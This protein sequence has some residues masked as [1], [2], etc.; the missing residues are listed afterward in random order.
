MPKLS[1][2]KLIHTQQPL[3]TLL[4]RSMDSL[5]IAFA[6]VICAWLLGSGWS[7][8]HTIYALVGV[9]AMQTVG[10]FLAIY[11]NWSLDN[12]LIQ[13]GMVAV[14]W[15]V[16]C[17]LLIVLAVLFERPFYDL[18]FKV[19]IY[20]VGLTTALLGFS[21]VVVKTGIIWL[22][23]HDRNT[24]RVAIAGAGPLAG[25]VI[26]KLKGNAW[27]D[28]R[29]T[30]IYDDR[31]PN[32]K[33]AANSQRKHDLIEGIQEVSGIDGNFDDLYRAAMNNDIDVVFVALPMRAENKIQ[34]ITRE[35]SATTVATYIV[36]DFYSIETHYT[37]LVDINGMPAVSIYENPTRGLRGIVKRLEDFILTC[38][39]LLI[40]GLPMVLIALGVKL[41]SKGPVFFMQRRY[42]LDGKPIKV[43]KFRSMRVM[44]NGEKVT[45]ATK[46][47]PRVTAFGGFLRKT[48]LDE[49][50]Q[51]FNVLFGTMSLVGPRPHAVSHNEEYRQVIGGYMLRHK[52]KPGITGWAQINGFR[53]ETDTLDKMEGRVLYDIDYIRHWSVFLD[54]KILFLTI[55]KGFV[56]K[57]AY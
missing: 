42:G 36:P 48:S 11:R 26:K 16:A 18:N 2:T 44:E 24:R 13:S 35:L 28:Y 21:R 41:S 29:M 50:P 54:L 5:V 15:L 3:V 34:T 20:W 38:G 49:L 7:R 37:H 23:K 30:G 17:A 53:G 55:F 51:L 40:F 10:E 22:R 45:Q 9:L 12:S 14:N 46:D 6:L 19:A 33:D 57:Q 43:F 25:Y 32:Q 47:D 27:I 1:D 52:I 39:I 31:L 4:V 56:S 8:T